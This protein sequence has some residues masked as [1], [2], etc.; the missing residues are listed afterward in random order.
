VVNV[1]GIKLAYRQ[2]F[3]LMWTGLMPRAFG[4]VRFVHIRRRDV[5]GQAVSHVI[6]AQTKVWTSKQEKKLSDQDVTFRQAQI[7]RVIDGIHEANAKFRTFF[8]VY[9]IRPVEVIYEDLVQ[10]LQTQGDR[11]VREIG[12][13]G[14]NATVRP[15]T[16]TLRKQRNALNDSFVKRVQ[17][18]YSFYG[19]GARTPE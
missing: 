14:A 9:G 7:V 4:E 1:L 19:M 12:Y 13:A 6:A 16:I 10:D 2:L 5:L 11:I 3:F 8:D 17:Q 18:H 15:D